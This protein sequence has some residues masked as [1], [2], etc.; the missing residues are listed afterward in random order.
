MQINVRSFQVS[1]CGS[2]DFFFFSFS[3]IQKGLFLFNLSDKYCKELIFKI[4]FCD[5]Y[6][7]YSCTC[8]YASELI[9]SRLGFLTFLEGLE[10]TL[11]AHDHFFA[12][13]HKLFFE[14]KQNR[15][16]FSYPFSHSS[17]I[18]KCFFVVFLKICWYV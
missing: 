15:H 2:V 10:G 16:R 4:N 17:N 14:R 11:F 7:N 18:S 12:M 3:L 13:C 5:C 1:A 9:L 8:F 6:F